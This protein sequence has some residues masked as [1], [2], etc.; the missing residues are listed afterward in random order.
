MR[1]NEREYRR[2]TST[3]GEGNKNARDFSK[4]DVLSLCNG[5][6]SVGYRGETWLLQQEKVRCHA[7]SSTYTIFT[8]NFISVGKL[9]VASENAQ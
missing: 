7:V 6:T 2:K 3:G 5:V 4:L 8:A 1:W 9:R